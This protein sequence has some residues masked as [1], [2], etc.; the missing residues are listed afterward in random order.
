MT[1]QNWHNVEELKF[2][3]I[4]YEKRVRNAGGEVAFE[5]RTRDYRGTV[6][7]VATYRFRIS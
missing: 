1:W 5:E 3:D 2:K 6:T 7:G 4:I